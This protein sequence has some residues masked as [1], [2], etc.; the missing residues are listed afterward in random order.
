M[1]TKATHP[2][3]STVEELDLVIPDMDGSADEQR[4][5]EALEQMPGVQAAL[6]VPEGA[7]IQYDPERLTKE[8][9]CQTLSQAGFTPALFQ[10]SLSGEANNVSQQ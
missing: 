1:T 5:Q 2:D 10:D 3:S 4:V 6:I 9:V 7:W 8:A